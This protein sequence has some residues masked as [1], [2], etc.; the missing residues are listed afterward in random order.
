MHTYILRRLLLIIP[1]LFIVTLIVF[2]MIR[3]VPGD[4]IDMMLAEQDIGS[5]QDYDITRELIEHRLGLDVSTPVQ[6]GRWLGVL[7]IEGEGF[8][9]VLQGYLG[10]SLWTETDILPNILLKFPPTFELGLIALSVSLII[11][12]PVGIFSAIRQDTWGD[13]IARSLSIVLIALPGFWVAT[14]V[15]VI[16]SILWKWSP[17][18]EFIPFV[19]NPL[20]NIK[21]CL[22][23]GFIL[24]MGLSGITMRMTR[25]MMLEV[26]R[27][28]YIRTA[29][30]KGLRERI[31]I[32]RHA[33]KN[34]FIPVVTI[35]GLQ[36][37]V[38]IAGSVIIETIFNIPGIG[39]YL[40]NVINDRD[41]TSLSGINLFVA[42]LVLLINLAVD[43]T[44]AY[45]DPRVHYK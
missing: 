44:Y 21:M 40:I 36:L 11:S 8:H 18:M 42:T 7:P 30:A 20:E 24:A 29:W 34:A 17:P 15:I 5:Q 19:E 41:Y 2:F 25:T 4:I 43:M 27:G 35:V 22:L 31:V 9:G 13:Y 6:Y 16:P 32:Y 10:R 23:P 38:M 12:I 37:P 33:L 45:L 14:V 28:D 39:R 26:L 1:T 3:F